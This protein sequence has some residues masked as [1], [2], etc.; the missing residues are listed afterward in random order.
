M[1]LRGSNPTP[2]A[3]TLGGVCVRAHLGGEPAVLEMC[4]NVTGSLP[5]PPRSPW[6]Y[7][8]TGPMSVGD[9]TLLPVMSA[10][11]SGAAFPVEFSIIG[12]LKVETSCG[13][14]SYAVVP[15]A[16]TTAAWSPSCM[17]S[18]PGLLID[19]GPLIDYEN[20]TVGNVSLTNPSGVPVLVSLTGFTVVD[21]EGNGVIALA[22]A[23]APVPLGPY[24]SGA[25]ALTLAMS[26]PQT[27]DGISLVTALTTGGNASVTVAVTGVAAIAGT[28]AWFPIAFTGTIDVNGEMTP[29]G[30]CTNNAQCPS[31]FCVTSGPPP[32]ACAINPELTCTNAPVPCGWGGIVA[33]SATGGACTCKCI[34]PCA[35]GAT[36]KCARGRMS[37]LCVCVCLFACAR[38]KSWAQEFL[39][40]CLNLRVRVQA[41]TLLPRLAPR[42]RCLHCCRCMLVDARCAHRPG[43]TM[44]PPPPR[45]GAQT[46]AGT[47]LSSPTC[48]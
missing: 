47:A 43:W 8:L 20:A 37:C 10:Y 12:D 2:F 32:Y 26:Y 7:A 11:L 4:Q 31:S 18:S 19:I 15:G 28:S 41:P 25:A 5:L 22:G 24:G 23:S 9:P 27:A 6:S 17:P 29:P 39:G 30:G 40:R 13:R 3:A 45:T 42:R 14:M 48:R 44:V 16:P 46:S 33:A 34:T 36:C 38:A 21:G 1:G 35:G